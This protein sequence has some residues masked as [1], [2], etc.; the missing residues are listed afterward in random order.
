MSDCE[1]EKLFGLRERVWRYGDLHGLRTGLNTAYIYLDAAVE[2][3]EAL[4]ELLSAM[5]GLIEST[6]E[7]YDIF[8][9]E[10]K[11]YLKEHFG[12]EEEEDDGTGT[13]DGTA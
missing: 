8:R 11:R 13:V 6:E 5:K 4:P 1:R 10:A 3:P 7:E 12:E 2:N 9:D